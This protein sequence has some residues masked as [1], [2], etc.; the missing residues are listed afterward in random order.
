MFTTCGAYVKHI[1]GCSAGACS[2]GNGNGQ[3]DCPQG[4][5]IDGSGNVWVAD[6]GNTRLEKFSSSGSYI[7]T[8]TDST[9]LIYQPGAV[10]FDTGGNFWIALNSGG[11]ANAGLK[12]NSSG[13]FLVGIS[14]TGG[15][16]PNLFEPSGVTVSSSNNV[17][18]SG[19][20]Q[21]TVMEYNS[22][23]SYITQSP[24]TNPTAS[25]I[26]ASGNVWVLWS[27]NL[28]KEYNSALT[29]SGTSFGSF[30]NATDVVIDSSGNFWI[31]DGGASKVYEYNSSGTQLLSF[32]SSG[33]GN[34]Q[35]AI[36]AHTGAGIAI[37]GR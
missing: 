9:N 2:S 18:F 37:G 15:G 28:L 21:G 13:T 32:G 11:H 27:A 31:I 12:Y 7:S 35:F 19:Y 6:T 1:G 5:T 14:G 8:F 36:G 16:E 23:G 26:D 33:T 25:V 3:F 34:G 24:V 4:V 29:T 17:Y 10:A 30:T 22:S 20:N